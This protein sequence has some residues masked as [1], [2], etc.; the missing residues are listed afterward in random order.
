M[1]ENEGLTLSLRPIQGDRS[2]SQGITKH[3]VIELAT[4]NTHEGDSGHNANQPEH[5]SDKETPLHTLQHPIGAGQLANQYDNQDLSKYDEELDL[6]IQAQ[7]NEEGNFRVIAYPGKFLAKALYDFSYQ[8]LR[9]P[10]IIPNSSSLAEAC[11]CIYFFFFLPCSYLRN[12][13]DCHSIPADVC[14]IETVN[15]NNIL[16]TTPSCPRRSHRELG[17]HSEGTIWNRPTVPCLRGPLPYPSSVQAQ[18][19]FA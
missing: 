1:S 18:T 17:V 15:A 7:E 10:I 12:F 5:G 19:K 14:L 11:L 9:P 6:D 16:R 13:I 2:Y 3:N 8:H 4:Y